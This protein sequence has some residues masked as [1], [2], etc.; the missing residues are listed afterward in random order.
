MS[1]NIDIYKRKFTCIYVVKYG[2]ATSWISYIC[3]LDDC[4]FYW[5]VCIFQISIYSAFNTSMDLDMKY[6]ATIKAAIYY[7]SKGNLINNAKFVILIFG[8]IA[9]H[10]N[11][12]IITAKFDFLLLINCLQ[13]I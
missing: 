3:Y 12:T 8:D 4:V 9:S 5:N 6:R 10:V 11:R 13:N 2:S 1:I 7:F